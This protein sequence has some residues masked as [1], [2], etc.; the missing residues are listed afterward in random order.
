MLKNAFDERAGLT[1]AKFDKDLIKA[2]HS[3]EP[4]HLPQPTLDKPIV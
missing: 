1:H 3:A 2:E 4:I